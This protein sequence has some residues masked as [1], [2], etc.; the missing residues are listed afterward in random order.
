VIGLIDGL[1]C[2]RQWPWNTQD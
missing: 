2:F 1:L